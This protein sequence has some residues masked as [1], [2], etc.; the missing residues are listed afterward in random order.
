MT[1]TTTVEHLHQ[2][3]RHLHHLLLTRHLQLFDLSSHWPWM[4]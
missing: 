1:T 2:L 4:L 3:T